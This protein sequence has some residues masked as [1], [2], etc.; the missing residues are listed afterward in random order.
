MAGGAR[1]ADMSLS[2]ASYRLLGLENQLGCQL[3][4]RGPKGLRSTSAGA[5]VVEH[6][7]RLLTKV[8]TLVAAI[9]AL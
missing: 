7:R 1:R 6:G 5:V 3:F 2:R 9:D 4:V 8:E